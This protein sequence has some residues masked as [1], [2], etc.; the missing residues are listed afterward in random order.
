MMGWIIPQLIRQRLIFRCPGA[1][2]VADMCYYF[3]TAIAFA[4]IRCQQL[5]NRQQII[6]KN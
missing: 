2:R 6:L 1:A 4:Q 3:Q 5:R